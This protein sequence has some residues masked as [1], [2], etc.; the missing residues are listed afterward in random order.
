MTDIL[1]VENNKHRIISTLAKY[2][3]IKYIA[4]T[5]KALFYYLNSPY[6]S[7]DTIMLDY[8]FGF[9]L[10]RNNSYAAMRAYKD[11]LKTKGVREIIIHSWNPWGRL[12]LYFLL[13][14]LGIKIIMKRHWV[15]F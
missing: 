2:P 3:S 15:L 9:I 8:D 1:L 7:F 13:K 6:T 12:R 11:K 5:E 14:N 4:K 10:T